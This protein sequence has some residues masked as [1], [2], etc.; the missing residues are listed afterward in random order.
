MKKRIAFS[1]ALLCAALAAGCSDGRSSE[2]PDRPDGYET[3]DAPLSMRVV[4]DTERPGFEGAE[5]IEPLWIEIVPARS[6]DLDRYEF[7]LR[8]PD[9]YAQVAERKTVDGKLLV[10]IGFI[11]YFVGEDFLFRCF[12]YDRLTQFRRTEEDTLASV[13]VLFRR[14]PGWQRVYPSD[15]HHAYLSD[16]HFVDDRTG[17]A[18][19]EE[20][21][22]VKTS[23]GGLSWTAHPLGWA[24]TRFYF[25]DRLH[26]I[27]YDHRTDRTRFTDDGGFTLYEGS[28][29]HPAGFRLGDFCM[30]D[31]Q[32]IYAFG[33][34]GY[35]A[36]STDRGTTWSVYPLD[37][38]NILRALCF[39]DRE[40]GIACGEAGIIL[41]TENGGETWEQVPVR[42]NNDLY[43]ICFPSTRTGFIGGVGVL[44]STRDGGATW[45]RTEQPLEDIVRIR[46]FSEDHGFAANLVGGIA[47]TRDGGATW[48]RISP[49]GTQG[50]D[51]V[52]KDEKTAL[53]L[54]LG[55]IY[56]FQMDY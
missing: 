20:R 25:H 32:T 42:A 48:R 35:L 33:L 52:F 14:I 24:V 38:L 19:G 4:G 31:P 21:E 13:E 26:G 22:C 46:F 56:R 16:L 2:D 6:E 39:R 30:V 45:T 15:T 7:L 44:L 10:R 54:S 5:P 23:D 55:S 18:V 53:A 8:G 27:A 3:I 49:D 50:L 29:T 11:T 17:I 37:R 47:E 12:V 34:P 40:H 41:R 28:W 36:R 9:P 51:V 43:C 1:T